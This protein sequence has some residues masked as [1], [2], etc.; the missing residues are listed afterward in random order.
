MGQ[1]SNK[2]IN[3]NFLPFFEAR[4]YIRKFDFKSTTEWK[5][6]VKTKP[7]FIPSLP[8]ITYKK[9]WISWYDWLGYS[10]KNKFSYGIQKILSILDANN[11]IYIT[12]KRFLKCKNILTW[13]LIT[14]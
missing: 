3:E 1:K 9:F 5:K 7:E 8:Y 11:I 6:W 2:E 12:G 13:H 4:D 14:C 10:E